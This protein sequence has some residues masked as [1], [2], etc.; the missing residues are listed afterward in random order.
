[1]LQKIIDISVEEKLIYDK[2]VPYWFKKKKGD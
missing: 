2:Y 1:M